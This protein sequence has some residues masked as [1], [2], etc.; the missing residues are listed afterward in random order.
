MEPDKLR[1][2]ALLVEGLRAFALSIG[3]WIQAGGSGP[4]R[5]S[6]MRQ[7][8]SLYR[9][10]R[11]LLGHEKLRLYAPEFEPIHSGIVWPDDAPAFTVAVGQLYNYVKTVFKMEV[12]R[13]KTKSTASG[14]NSRVFISHGRE[15]SALALVQEFIGALGLDPVICIKR[16]SLGV[17][18]DDK[19]EDYI[20]VCQAAII[21][22]TGDDQLTGST[23]FQPRQNIIHEIGLAQQI[24]EN[25][26]TYLLEENTRFPSNIA[27]K[28]YESFTKDNLTKAFIAVAR[29]LKA[30]GLL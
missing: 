3:A 23:V 9:Q 19:V 14:A 28:V 1:E 13:A 11:E 15:S 7:Y 12:D 21:L 29:D 27:P 5:K 4:D 24:L 25:R 20:G 2:L 18:V 8:E 17:S 16:A 10:T 30:F 26:I 22:A 6:T